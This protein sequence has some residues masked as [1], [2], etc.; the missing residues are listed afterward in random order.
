[1]QD[2]ETRSEDDGICRVSD[3]VPELGSTRSFV[4][5]EAK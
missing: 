3:L 2:D 5:I 1:M 4:T